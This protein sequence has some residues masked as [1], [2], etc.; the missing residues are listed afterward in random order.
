M[1][2]L[3]VLD[4]PS[5]LGLRP[6]RPG[7]IP[8]AYKLPDALRR[9]RLPERIGARDAGRV[10]APPYSPERDSATGF[11]NGPAI[12]AFSLALADEVAQ[13]VER[14]EMPVV[15]GGDCSIL[16]GGALAL[17]RT[18]TYGLMFIDGHADFCYPR[19]PRPDLAFAAAGLDLALATGHGP[20]ALTDIDGRKPYFSEQHV[21]LLGCWTDPLDAAGYEVEALT[22]SQM[23]IFDIERIRRAGAR[24]T[25]HAALAA[26]AQPEIEG[27][28]IHLD[29]D[30]LDRRWMPAVD[31]PNENGLDYPQLIELL[32]PLVRSERA[33]GIEIT[34]FDPD[35]DP[36]GDLAAGFVDALVVS[37]AAPGE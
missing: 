10:P 1:K 7:H 32:G 4:A 15:L 21:A 27:F 13:I 29:A 23:H 5:N 24:E 9:Q 33:V 16:L 6:L 18:G 36:T 31:A 12:R 28:W 14:G 37:F 26:L 2:P 20:G 30:V 22:G 11:R 19:A 3:A 8:G 17:R 35:L 25:A 34:I